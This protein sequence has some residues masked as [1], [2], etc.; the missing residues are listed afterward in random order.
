MMTVATTN[1][2][3]HALCNYRPVPVV[4]PFSRWHQYALF[5]PH[6]EQGNE[7]YWNATNPTREI[8][9]PVTTHF[10]TPYQKITT[11]ILIALLPSMTAW[12]RPAVSSI[13]ACQTPAR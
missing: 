8:D 6:R 13:E 1:P 7:C 5:Y 12:H 3:L 10:A 11:L 9:I 4:T 2:P